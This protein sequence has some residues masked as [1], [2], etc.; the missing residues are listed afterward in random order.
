[1]ATPDLARLSM[2]AVDL[3][4]RADVDASGRLVEDEHLRGGREGATTALSAGCRRKAL[5]P[6][7]PG[8]GTRM[9]SDLNASFARAAPASIDDP[10]GSHR[11]STPRLML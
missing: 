6:L 4:L 8:P 7:T 2:I 10:P 3:R 11:A 9:F 1:M 5:R